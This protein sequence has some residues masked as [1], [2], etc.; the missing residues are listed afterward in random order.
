V[1]HA[2]D[3]VDDQATAGIVTVKEHPAC[4]GMPQVNPGDAV[5]WSFLPPVRDDRDLHDDQLE[6]LSKIVT[7]P[8]DGT[9]TVWSV[10]VRLLIAVTKF[11]SDAR[12][13]D[14]DVAI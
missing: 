11:W 1:L 7:V 4:Q 8:L 3:Q 13:S 6:L 12:I 2:A 10:F 14:G 9:V 5:P